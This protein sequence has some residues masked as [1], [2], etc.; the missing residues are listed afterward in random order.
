[1]RP[2]ESAGADMNDSPANLIPLIRWDNNTP[3]QGFEF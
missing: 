1:M 3:P 2:V